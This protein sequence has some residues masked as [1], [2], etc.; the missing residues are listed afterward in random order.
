MSDEDIAA[1]LQELGLTPTGTCPR[2]LSNGFAFS[3]QCSRSLAGAIYAN[4]MRTSLLLR[5]SA[6][7]QGVRLFN[8]YILR[9]LQDRL[10]DFQGTE[11]T[12]SSPSYH[13]RKRAENVGHLSPWT[14]HRMLQNYLPRVLLRMKQTL[15]VQKVVCQETQFSHPRSLKKQV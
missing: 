12:T 6:M 8:Q 14:S 7:K 9:H 10:V 1:A 13:M 4:H 2:K 3:Q 5:V 11:K 15:A